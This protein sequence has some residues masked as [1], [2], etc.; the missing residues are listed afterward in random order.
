MTSPARRPFSGSCSVDLVQVG[1]ERRGAAADSRRRSRGK[2][3]SAPVSARPLPSGWRGKPHRRPL[4]FAV[5]GIDFRHP[6]NPER[7]V[8][9]CWSVPRWAFGAERE[10]WT[11]HRRGARRMRSL[12][13]GALAAVYASAQMQRPDGAGAARA[14]GPASGP[15]ILVVPHNG[16]DPLP[17]TWTPQLRLLIPAWPARAGDRRPQ[18]A[19][20]DHPARTRLPARPSGG[21]CPALRAAAISRRSPAARSGGPNS[22]RLHPAGAIV[23]AR[24]RPWLSHPEPPERLQLP[25]D[26]P[27]PI[28]PAVVALP[29]AALVLAG[30]GSG[31]KARTVDA[32]V[33]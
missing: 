28:G 18:H 31:L 3:W 32:P 7:F 15:R 4:L 2:L 30:C 9:P 25:F 19:L 21:P 12:L 11:G 13:S 1:A 29:A 33:R 23:G 8:V 14:I 10:L 20:R 22:R 24:R 5:A 26:E 6:R 17:L 16:D 27:E